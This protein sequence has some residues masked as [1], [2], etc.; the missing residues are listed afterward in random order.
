MRLPKGDRDVSDGDGIVRKLCC[1]TRDVL[2]FAPR[3][4]AEFLF[5]VISKGRPSNV[6]AMEAQLKNAQ[7]VTWFVGAGE[8]KA[9]RAAGATDVF[10]G[11]GLCA[12]RNAALDRAAS[13]GKVCVQLSD[14][15]EGVNFIDAKREW[16]CENGGP[17]DNGWEKPGSLTEANAI[18]KKATVRPLSLLGAA[19]LID[20]LSRRAG[21]KLGGVYPTPNTGQA[22][23]SSSVKTAHF[24]VG[25]FIVV[26][27]GGEGSPRFD[28][29]MTLKED[30]MFTAFHLQKYGVVA[31]CCRLIMYA[32]HYTNVGG[33]VDV[34]TDASEAF[35]IRR[36]R[37]TWPGVFINSPRGPSEVVMRW[38]LRDV[39]IGGTRDFLG[40]QP[41]PKNRKRPPSVLSVKELP[42][43]DL[44]VLRKGLP[45]LDEWELE[46]SEYIG[47]RI[48]RSHSEGRRDEF[49][50]GGVI[51]W[52]DA[53]ASDF[54]P[55]G[56]AEPVALFRVRFDV[57]ELDGDVEDLEFDE[58]EE[59]L[60]V[61]ESRLADGNA[62]DTLAA[63][64]GNSES[65]AESG[66]ESDEESSA[67]SQG[68]D[69]G[70][71]PE[72]AAKKQRKAPPGGH[73][74][75]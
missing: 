13:L 1:G 60:L 71:K 46:G 61:E 5:C 34:R 50:Y 16:L 30:Y 75:L 57:G 59:S 14:D 32:L 73:V 49:S 62:A 22:M 15:V 37:K 65:D 8:A 58:V 38:E 48:V 51:A 47:M 28:E 23:S 18:A 43:V 17:D 54:I 10:E 19:Q 74:S 24:I 40:K 21:A 39:S 36:L 4:A 12:S 72:R 29:E 27:N 6:E 69:G 53:D 42:P 66:S 64:D 33:A 7:G 25:D 55:P 63:N 41:A 52:L 31:R 20:S 11:G 68:D 9:Y 56:G 45:D 44:V 35:N 67:P 26:Q 3:E 2:E 70:W